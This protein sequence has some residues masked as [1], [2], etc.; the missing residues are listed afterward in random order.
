MAAVVAVARLTPADCKGSALHLWN[1][2]GVDSLAPLRLI[3]QLEMQFSITIPD[4]DTGQ[5]HTIGDLITIVQR[6][7]GTRSPAGPTR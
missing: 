2:P 7:A 4:E 3:R 5:A 1:D 6:L